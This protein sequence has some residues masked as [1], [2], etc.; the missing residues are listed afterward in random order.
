MKHNEIDEFSIW[1]FLK[2]IE[3]FWEFNFT[4]AVVAI[5][6]KVN[7]FEHAFEIL[8]RKGEGFFKFAEENAGL[9]TEHL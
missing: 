7:K 9:F 4:A 6:H 8:G 2:I 1:T 3:L 5:Y